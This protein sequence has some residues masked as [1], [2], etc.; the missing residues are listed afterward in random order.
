MFGQ[1]F[2][3]LSYRFDGTFGGVT[4]LGCKKIMKPG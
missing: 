4:A 2:H 3:P 1:S